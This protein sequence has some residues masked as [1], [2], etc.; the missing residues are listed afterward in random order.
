MTKRWKQVR[1]FDSAD[2]DNPHPYYGGCD[3]MGPDG[4]CCE[5]TGLYAHLDGSV[6]DGSGN[7]RRKAP[8]HIRLQLAWH[9]L[10]GSSTRC[11]HGES[12]HE[13]A[14]QELADQAQELDMGYGEQERK[15]G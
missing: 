4:T 8:F 6:S 7:I 10:C 14:M 12:Q 13:H 3:A 2:I 15:E 1:Y 9:A 11:T 5:C